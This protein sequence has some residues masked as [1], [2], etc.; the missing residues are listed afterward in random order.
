MKTGLLSL[1]PEYADAIFAGTKHYEYRRK[2]PKV[3][4][5]TRF[6]IY[7]TSP[8]K[9][10]IGEIIVDHI[11]TA[12]PEA[13]WKKTGHAGGIAKVQLLEYFT[14]LEEA[15]ALHVG[16]YTRYATPKPLSALRRALPGFTP[17]QYLTW[18]TP[19]ALS[20]LKHA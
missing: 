12:T 15:H 5:P 20:A 6:L 11:L 16:S 18:L 7:V 19:K 10:L 3:G 4:V 8:R 1:H 13:I 14:G 9:E 17:P 2:A